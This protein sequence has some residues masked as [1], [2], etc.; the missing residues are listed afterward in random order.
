MPGRNRAQ[1][2][3]AL[4]A[5]E[6]CRDVK[7][8]GYTDRLSVQP[9]QVVRFMVSCVAPRYRADIV[10]LI[11]G[12][13]NPAGPGF[14]AEEIRTAVSG[15][16]RGRRQTLPKGSYVRVPDNPRLRLTHGLSLQA[17]IYPTTPEKGSQGIVTKWST[18]SRTGYGL[19]IDE[20]GE[21]AL[22][23]G[24]KDGELERVTSGERL[25]AFAWY[26]VAGAFDSR[27]GKV[28]LVQ[29][30]IV[31]W[32]HE[33]DVVVET[34]VC[35]PEVGESPAPLVIAGY[36][37]DGNPATAEVAGHFNGKV[38]SPRVFAAG[39]SLDK[40]RA[41]AAGLHPDAID[42]RL[43]ASWDFARDISSATAIDSSPHRHHG[44]VINMPARGV[45][46]HNWTGRHSHF[47]DAP[48]EYG[49]IHFHDDDLDDARWLVDFEFEVPGDMRSGVYAA[50][51]TS[52]A[53]HDCVPFFVTPKRGCPSARTAFLA[54]TFSYIAYANKQLDL[55]AGTLISAGLPDDFEYPREEQDRYIVEN[56]LTSLYDRH[57]DGSGVC[58]SSRLRPI[59]NMR[60]SYNLPILAEGRGSPHQL[61]ADLHLLDWMESKGHR[62]DVVT[63]EDLHV[64]GVDLLSQYRVIV[65]GTHPEYWSADMLDAL[66]HYLRSGGRM[67]YLGGNGFYWV[68]SVEP[69]RGH[70]LEIRRWGG[71]ETWEAAPGEYHHSTSGELGGIWRHRG[72]APQKLVGVGFTSQGYDRNAPYQRHAASFDPEA[73]FI[74]EGVA[75]EE[76]IGDFPSLVLEHGAAGFEIDRADPEL[77]TPAHTLILATARDFSDSYQHVAEEILE[78]DSRQGGPVNPQVRSDMVYLRYPNAGAVF[79]VGSISWCGCLSY[80]RY[81]NAVSRI[82]DN[83]LRKFAA[84]T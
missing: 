77:G 6:G 61:S 84:E 20:R 46:G 19:C 14:K 58:Y 64:E 9:T 38:D 36:L 12:D 74:F 37:A 70:T 25:Q 4:V 7:I 43:V 31:E 28:V 51:L 10:R 49:A 18:E 48:K 30:P 33:S 80:H 73:S 69:R 54:P 76:L 1:S 29:K 50:R 32:P 83:V 2:K 41:L 82:T 79:S 81:D 26:F 72:R 53:S 35:L 22:W 57:T 11:H 42:E 27:T 8:V 63:D 23:L 17:W 40:V 71:T 15:E 45:T 75:D 34:R 62:Y 55:E 56:G 66:E 59:L 16:Y 21:L 78:S 65:S 68:T 13:R 47:K 3:S 5:P 39:L 24:G 67:M 44:A 52:G 60:P